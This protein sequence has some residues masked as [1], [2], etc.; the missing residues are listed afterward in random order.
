MATKTVTFSPFARVEGDLSLRVEIV[1]GVVSSARTSGTLFRG[2]ERMLRGR[3]P[4]DSLVILPRICGQCGVAHS[5]A[6]ARALANAAGVQS[7]PN[8]AL[9]QAVMQAVEVV[10]GHLA[11]FSLTFAADMASVPGAEQ[12]GEQFAPVSGRSF[13]KWLRARRVLLPLMGLFAGKWPNTLAIRPG[14]VT[15]PLSRGELVRAK[16]ILAEFA[17]MVQHELLGCSIER[18]LAN[19]SAADL[20]R[21]LGEDEHGRG[22]MGRFVAA[23]LSAGLQDLGRGPGR[24]LSSGGPELPDGRAWLGSGY[25][26]AGAVEPLDESRIAEDLASSWFEGDNLPAHPATSEAVPAADRADAYSWAKAPRYAGRSV[27]VGPMARMVVDGDPLARDLLDRHGSS[28]FTRVLLRLHEMLRLLTALEE[29]LDRIDPVEPFHAQMAPLESGTGYA[30]T[31]ATRGT[32]GH[33]LAV[34]DGRISRYQIITPTGWNLSPRDKDGGPGPL[35]EAL[36]GT[37]V[38]DPEKATNLAL[39]VRSYDPCLYC[40]VH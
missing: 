3:L 5:A 17:E 34:E 27:E 36:V 18:W 14:G 22:D 1:D 19:R 8:G 25:Y 35:E 20:D 11:H 16:G 40:S 7:P 33:W 10:L 24:F 30:L 29:W 4:T 6:A 39:V 31:E 38:P 37:P 2:F 9:A 21:W 26:E 23:A 32:L 12:F 13:R 28:V 15:K